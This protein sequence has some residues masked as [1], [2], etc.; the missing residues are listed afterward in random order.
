MNADIAR[1][2]T[3]RLFW[4][5]L[6]ASLLSGSLFSPQSA[7]HVGISV[8]MFGVGLVI[9]FAWVHYDSRVR[10]VHLSRWLKMG[11]AAFSLIFVPAY[12]YQTRGL[13]KG[14]LIISVFLLKLIGTFAAI[15][16][17]VTALLATGFVP[18]PMSHSWQPPTH[19][20]P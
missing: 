12:V 19:V 17:L 14:T 16:I 20:K 18:N 15:M 2:N 11:I 1:R 6:A 9:P 3:Q 10:G 8:L 13:A 4:I 7:I 5:W